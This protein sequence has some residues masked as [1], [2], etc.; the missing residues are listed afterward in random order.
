M[1]RGLKLAF[2][3]F[4]LLV[5][6]LTYLEAT[7]PEP[8]NWNPSYL[9]TDKIALGSFVLFDSWE[10]NT[11]TTIEKVRIPPY[12]FLDENPQGTYFFLNNTMAFDDSELK[13]S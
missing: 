1:S 2:G 11:N 8:I 13:N 7:Q 4:L 5:L 6:F 9:E 3:A 12:E 10:K